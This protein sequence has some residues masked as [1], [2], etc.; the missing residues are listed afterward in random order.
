MATAEYTPDDDDES[1][2]PLKVHQEVE[3]LGLNQYSGWWMVRVQDYRTGEPVTGWVPASY[4]QMSKDQ[5]D[6][7]T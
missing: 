7:S 4:L 5:T 1:G 3:V 6:P 2:V